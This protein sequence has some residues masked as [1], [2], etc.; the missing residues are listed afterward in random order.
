MTNVSDDYIGRAI[1]QFNDNQ[2]YMK[3]NQVVILQPQKSPKTFLYENPTLLPSNKVDPDIIN[4]AIAHPLLGT[5]LYN[6]KKYDLI[7]TQ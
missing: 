6:E 2:A 5:W 3:G 7:R 4:Q 1:M